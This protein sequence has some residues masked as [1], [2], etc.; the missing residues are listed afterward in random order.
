LCRSPCS[1]DIAVLLLVA[2]LAALP[3]HSRADNVTSWFDDLVLDGSSVSDALAELDDSFL[4]EL[5]A[6]LDDESAAVDGLD[7]LLREAAAFRENPVDV[8]VAAL[9]ELLRVPFLDP[10]SAVRIVVRRDALGPAESLDELVTRGCLSR[11][12]LPS[13]RP[14]LV[15]RPEATS[16]I[17][18][19]VPVPLVGVGVRAPP[20]S[21]EMASPVAWELRIRAATQE[22][23]EAAWGGRRAA[24]GFA[25]YARLRVSYADLLDLSVACE[26]DIGEE[27]LADHSAFSLVWRGGA[28]APE[29]GPAFSV[30]LGDFAGSWGQG[31]LLRS[32]GFPSEAAYP[33]RRDSIRRYDGAG[34]AASRR[35][36][37]I[38]AS[39]EKICVRAVM[40]RTRL[41]AAIGEDGLATSIRTTGYH[42]TEGERE[43]AL[44]LSESLVGVR[45]SVERSPGLELSA[46]LL[47]F[48]FSPE[49]APGD[50]VRQRFRFS[51][52]ELTAGGFDVR[53][54][55]G[56]FSA[57]CEVATTS[58]GGIAALAAGRL[59]RGGCRVSAGGAYLSRG[60]WSPLGGGVPG[61]SGGSNGAV[62]W[63]GAEY[64]SG[65]DWKVW[66]ASS[67]TKKPW[68][69]YHSRLPN[70]S[71]AVTVGGELRTKRNWR[72]AVESKVR[73]RSDSEGNPP[74][75]AAGMTRRIRVSLRTE[76]TVP[77]TVSAWRVASL[78]DGREEGSALAVALRIDGSIGGRSSYTA[79]L[80]SMISQG[81]VPSFVQYEPRLPGE[82]GL[83]SLNVPGARWYIRLKT[84][85][86]A[87]LGLSVRLSGGPERGQTQFGLGLDARG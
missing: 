40:A 15:A 77:V 56:G 87:G 76:G 12:V 14:Y 21:Q 51:G 55:I 61:F 38:I 25:S 11:E 66:A 31:L 6:G 32:G 45:V 27:N 19:A 13:V 35:G 62:G 69:S 60:Y 63:V 42:R 29:D 41:D 44:S 81:N 53:T 9:T 83:A 39:R 7:E 70:G 54:S 1:C 3:T 84:G 58:A 82:F 30:G 67:V 17:G 52:D 20:V 48:G 5:L 26:K 65:A 74:V 59:R 18:V 49:L 80:T 24:T 50:P 16:P 71:A 43:G 86:P 57:G 73:A 37:F 34:E 79:G 46:S 4:R 2:L 47:R 10:A 8:N 68:R 33:R 64:R 28:D 78:S 23:W 85:L 22:R 36:A 72:I 75:T